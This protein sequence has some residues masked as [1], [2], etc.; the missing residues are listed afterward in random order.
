MSSPL[1]KS[2]FK[3]V[4]CVETAALAIALGVTVL[5]AG[6]NALGVAGAHA[7]HIAAPP[8]EAGKLAAMGATIAAGAA[9]GSL[10]TALVLGLV[11]ARARRG[12]VLKLALAGLACALVQI[13]V[14]AYPIA[15]L[16]PYF[17]S[18]TPPS[19][20]FPSGASWDVPLGVVAAIG[21]AGAV[22]ASPL[23]AVSLGVVVYKLE[24]WTRP[25]PAAQ[26]A[27]K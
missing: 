26:W 21:L 19:A 12:R 22:L 9:L 23:I 3:S 15:A 25:E 5:F 8:F 13:V 2:L 6:A 11:A 18:N 17:L 16:S 24:R 7:Q 14:S 4:V 27:A 10:P 20:P 1:G